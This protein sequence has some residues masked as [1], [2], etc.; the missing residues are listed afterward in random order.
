[1]KWNDT[2]EIS[3]YVEINMYHKDTKLPVNLN[4]F[5]SAI[6][7]IGDEVLLSVYTGGYLS[8]Y[9]FVEDELMLIEKEVE[10]DAKKNMAFQTYL[11]PWYGDYFIGSGIFDILIEN[12]VNHD[13][14]GPKTT[15]IE[16]IRILDINEEINKK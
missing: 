10:F 12:T 1:M 15:V 8:T 5:H 4:I 13:F 11:M 9:V 16:K 6:K 14:V 3:N 7:N 2:Y